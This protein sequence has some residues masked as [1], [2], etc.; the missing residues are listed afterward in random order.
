MFRRGLRRMCA[1]RKGVWLRRGVAVAP[2]LSVASAAV[3]G[4]AIRIPAQTKRVTESIPLDIVHRE[5]SEGDGS[6]YRWILH[7]LFKIG[8]KI[9]VLWR[10][11]IIGIKFLP[12]AFLYPI[13]VSF[14]PS[15]RPLYI[16]LLAYQMKHSGPCLLKLGQWFSTRR[17]IIAADVCEAFAGLTSNA[18]YHTKAD[19]E[20]QFQLAFGKGLEDIF[21]DF[22]DDPIASGS[23]AQVYHAKLRSPYV[24]KEWESGEVAVKVRHPGVLESVN[25]DLKVLRGVFTVVEWLFPDMAWL[26]LHDIVD[27]FNARMA[28]QCN[29]AQE[30]HNLH[31]FR[32]N[33]ASASSVRFPEPLDTLCHPLVLTES[34]ERGVLIDHFTLENTPRDLCRSIA[35]LTMDAFL[36]MCIVDNFV[37]ADLHPGNILVDIP[38]YDEN[39]PRNDSDRRSML[40]RLR[41]SMLGGNDG[42]TPQLVILDCGLTSE[43]SAK[44]QETFLEMFLAF[45][46][47]RS[48]SVSSLIVRGQ[49]D[50]VGESAASYQREM[51][52]LVE[53]AQVADTYDKPLSAVFWDVFDIGRRHKITIYSN[54]TTISVGTVVMEGISRRLD[55]EL[56]LFQRALPILLRDERSRS[57]LAARLTRSLW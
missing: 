36:Q 53:K 31:R 19:T 42:P 26:N 37:H 32:E 52:S 30:A 10:S 15:L 1:G 50:A 9:G 44:D 40:A 57:I 54:F 56:N 27:S 16:K 49:E 55:P 38:G 29:L 43:L 20:R 34:F 23:I 25:T 2:L 7:R 11:V 51:S 12:L 24:P 33:F 47:G 14:L 41:S 13:C 21:E 5:V 4:P 39:A 8:E 17:D 6:L 3:S 48:D 35:S 45:A 28:A 22:P 18:P 46:G